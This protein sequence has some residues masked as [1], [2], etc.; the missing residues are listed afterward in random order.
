MKDGDM[1]GLVALQDDKGFVALA[2]DGGNYKVVMYTG[3]KN[4]ESLKDSKAISGSKVYLR[5]DFDLPID[6]GTA[7]F[8]YSTDG[9]TCPKIKNKLTASS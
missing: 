3:N 5:I 6:R 1:A 2:K 9:N 4:G 7:Y 8:Y